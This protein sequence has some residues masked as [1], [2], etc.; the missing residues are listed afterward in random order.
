M[1][2]ITKRIR[3]FD[4]RYRRRKPNDCLHTIRD[5]KSYGDRD[6]FLQAAGFHSYRAYLASTTWKTVRSHILDQYGTCHFC[7]QPARAVHH[8]LDTVENLL[9]RSGFGLIPVCR[10]CH[11]RMHFHGKRFLPLHESLN[12]AH[13]VAIGK[14]IA[15]RNKSKQLQ[16][17][18]SRPT[19]GTASHRTLDG[20]TSRPRH[21]AGESYPE[22][23]EA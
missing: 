17:N 14:P 6:A 12:R 5:S 10:S 4:D 20:R 19:C 7:D 9:G 8:L 13:R 11:K 23:A 1:P 15:P 2:G 16:A 21:D 18:H 22:K 3:A